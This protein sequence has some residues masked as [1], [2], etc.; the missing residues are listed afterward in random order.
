MTIVVVIVVPSASWSLLAVVCDCS[1]G[2]CDSSCLD[3]YS[4]THT[5]IRSFL[6]R[7]NSASLSFSAFVAVPSLDRIIALCRSP[8]RIPVSQSSFSW[9]TIAAVVFTRLGCANTRSDRS[10][11]GSSCRRRLNCRA[12]RPA[13]LPTTRCR[14]YYCRQQRCRL[15]IMTRGNL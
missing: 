4:L 15:L 12:R 9:A 7:T 11:S 1:C 10:S 14:R 6:S 13:C 5:F 3:E 2:L 8:G